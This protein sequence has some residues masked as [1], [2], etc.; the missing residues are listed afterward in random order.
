MNLIGIIFVIGVLGLLVMTGFILAAIIS[1]N[2]RTGQ[3]LRKGFAQRV[4]MLR[5]RRMLE[6]RKIN[7]EAYLHDAMIHDIDRHIRIC[8]GCE[9][10]KECDASLNAVGKKETDLSFCP[11]DADFVKL[12]SQQKDGG[13]AFNKQHTVSLSCGKENGLTAAGPAA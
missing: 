10:L 4:R 3:R 12:K 13:Q 2:F 7:V 8:E 5:L 6:R 9:K 1:G 11:N